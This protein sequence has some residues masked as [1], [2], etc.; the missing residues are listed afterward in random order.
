MA[1]E[2]EKEN[3]ESSEKPPATKPSTAQPFVIPPEGVK[4]NLSD[5][6]VGK[7]ADAVIGKM[8]DPIK[9]ILAPVSV[10][11]T[12]ASVPSTPATAKRPRSRLLRWFE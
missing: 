7:V 4:A 1:K 11:A 10:D 6:S 12:P 5:E 9:A 2:S 3:S 8:L